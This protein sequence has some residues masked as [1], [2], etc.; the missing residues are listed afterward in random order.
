MPGGGFPIQNEGDLRNAIRAI[1]RAKNPGAA[2]AHIKQRAR[3]LGLTRLLPDSW[4]KRD[5]PK[6][7]DEAQDRKLIAEMLADRDE[8]KR[9]SVMGDFLK[10]VEADLNVRKALAGAVAAAHEIDDDGECLAAISKSVGQC[11]DHLAVPG[12]ALHAAV[13]AISKGNSNMTLEELTASVEKLAK[14]NSYLEQL[15]K[16]S[17]PHRLYA[18]KIDEADREAFVAKSDKERDVIVKEKKPPPKDDMEDMED[19]DEKDE[20][21]EK[22]NGEKEKRKRDIA[23]MAELEKRVGAFEAEAEQRICKQLCRDNGLPESDHEMLA[24]LRKANPK[25]AAEMLKR[26]RGLAAQANPILFTE[27]GKGGGGVDDPGAAIIA[28]ATELMA[29][30]NKSAKSA[31]E[32]ITIEKARM[33]VRE[34]NP[35]L[36]KA[37]REIEQ[38]RRLGRAA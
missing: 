36:Y 22:D 12:A 1:G 10:A 20:K 7:D 21:D 19:D 3:S 17:E 34:Q 28:K 31:A 33:L 25:A 26:T 4:E 16:L 8:K 24:S 38:R 27:L 6:H 11:I 15:F 18:L 9:K 14:R 32:R 23:K 37:E 29:S 2:K 5:K 30:I 13:A 35:D